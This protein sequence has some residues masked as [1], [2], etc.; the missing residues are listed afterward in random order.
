MKKWLFASAFALAMASLAS[1]SKN[2]VV[3]YPSQSAGTGKIVLT[4][5]APVTGT[6]VTMNDKMLVARKN[7]KS[8]TIT[9]VPAGEHR[10]NISADSWMYKEPLRH[11]FNLNVTDGQEV[12]KIVDR[13]PF[14]TGYYVYQAASGLTSVA[15][16]IWLL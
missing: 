6:V 4:P 8:V 10:V 3:P 11:E 5:T 13:P 9:N 1:C 16:L 15:M 7:V 12:S 14:S 2:I